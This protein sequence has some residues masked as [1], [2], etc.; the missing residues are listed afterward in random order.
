[1]INRN[2]S[3]WYQPPPKYDEIEFYKTNS[4]IIELNTID[5][6]KIQNVPW[7]YHVMEW[8][9]IKRLGVFGKLT[10]DLIILEFDVVFKRI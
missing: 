10:T 8:S 3:D 2:S 6:R 9:Y 4:Q 1:M 7:S 5:K